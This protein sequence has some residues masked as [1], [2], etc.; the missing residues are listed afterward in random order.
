MDTRPACLPMTDWRKQSPTTSAP[1]LSVLQLGL[2]LTYARTSETNWRS[3]ADMPRWLAECDR[4]NHR[5]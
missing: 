2:R 1:P 5:S 4:C 3:P